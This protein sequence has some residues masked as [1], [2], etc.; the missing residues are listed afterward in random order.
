MFSLRNYVSSSVLY[1]HVCLF[2]FVLFVNEFMHY[3]VMLFV[4]D[5]DGDGDDDK[6]MVV[7][8]MMMIMITMV[9]VVVSVVCVVNEDNG[10]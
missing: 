4:G 1:V 2:V 10:D 8:N 3:V 7:M 5:D 9:V 6:I